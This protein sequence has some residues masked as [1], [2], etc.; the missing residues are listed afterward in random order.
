MF[1]ELIQ[2]NNSAAIVFHFICCVIVFSCRNLLHRNLLLAI[3]PSA[4]M[5]P[6]GVFSASHVKT[7]INCM[8]CCNCKF[9][10][11]QNPR[12]ADKYLLTPLNSNRARRTSNQHEEQANSI[13]TAIVVC[14]SREV[15]I[16]MRKDTVILQCFSPPK[17]TIVH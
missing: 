4:S 8:L 15:V 1:L 2:V 16:R 17:I 9:A 3:F 12:A 11:Y 10:A 13:F 14:V 6:S 7:N 5:G